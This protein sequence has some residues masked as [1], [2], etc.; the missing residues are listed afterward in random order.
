MCTDQYADVVDS[1]D[2]V[3]TLERFSVDALRRYRA[4][5]LGRTADQAAFVARRLPDGARVVELASGNGRLLVEL[6][7][8][9]AVAAAVGLEVAA[10]RVA[11]AEAWARDEGLTGVTHR[12]VDVLR[13][14]LPSEMDAVVCIT[15][16]FAY[17]DAM[18]PGAGAG[19]LRK[20]HEALR[21][22]GLIVL[23]LYPHPAWRTA[24]EASGDGELRTWQELG[25]ADPWRYYLSHLLW[26]EEHH[27]LTHRK[28][29]VHRTSGE[30]DDSRREHLRLYRTQEIRA[31]LE[32][33]G[34]G[35]VA[36]FGGWD[37]RSHAP[38]DELVV[39]TARRRSD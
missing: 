25:P 31:E 5:L 12:T 22:G 39:I 20:A 13:Q 3:E 2:G 4:D 17:F 9:G 38:E 10:S 6:A 34:F 21:P 26:D 1:Y 35:D 18:R 19:V 15:G 14:E 33:S 28:T 29:F 11:F 23:E 30:V 7:R 8:R 24:L 36:E 37:E 16:A 32:A 27:V